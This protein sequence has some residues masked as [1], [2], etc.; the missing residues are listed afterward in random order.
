MTRLLLDESSRKI[1]FEYLKNKTKCRTY[2]ELAKFL[3]ISH[4]GLQKWMYGSIYL[5]KSIVP[6]EIF[7]KLKIIDEQNENWGC[8]KGGNTTILNLRRN[9]KFKIWQ[10]SGCKK[11]GRGAI[12]KL[13][14]W[15]RKNPEKFRIKLK[16]GKY[17]S[18]FEKMKQKELEFKDYF[19]SNDI[20]F[21]LDNIEFSSS[22]KKRNIKMPPCLTRDLAEE[23]GIHIGDGTLPNKKY[24]FSVR[25]DKNEERYYTD[26]VFSLYEKL[27]NLKLNKLER[28][29]V[30]GF[31]ISSKALYQF[32]NKV[33][34]MP[35]GDKVKNGIDVPICILQCRNKEMIKAFI[36]GAFDTDGC[37]SWI[38]TK[39]YPIIEVSIRSKNFIKNF[40]YLLETLGFIPSVCYKSYSIR[41]NGPIMFLKWVKE[42]G[43]NNPK[44]KEKMKKILELLP[45]SNLDKLFSREDATLRIW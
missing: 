17:K 1:L 44:H 3:N 18:T 30:C 26:Y 2:K 24:Y 23:I 38:K 7:S 43:S 8:S 13:R 21:K 29:S 15:I 40:K 28:Q 37:V 6:N 27:F 11:G 9:N 36:R 41:L 20:I 19:K 14:E 35:V 33:I 12:L 10:R 31:E 5:P 22:D 39:K 25:G 42:I 4:K 34:G 32:K 45:W 16:E